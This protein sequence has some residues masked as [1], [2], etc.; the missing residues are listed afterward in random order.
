M[1]SSEFG[2]LLAGSIH[3]QVKAGP[4]V[5]QTAAPLKP[6]S[7]LFSSLQEIFNSD[8]YPPLQNKKR[9]DKTRWN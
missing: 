7:S 9:A 6:A 5:T 1:T 4:S 3:A 2:Q 8:H